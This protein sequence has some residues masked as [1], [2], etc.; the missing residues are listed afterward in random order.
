LEG[1]LGIVVVAEGPAADAPDHRAMPT[2]QGC[3]SRP[4]TT[5]EVVLQQLPIGLLRPVAQ[6]HRPAQ[7]FED[8]ACLA[9]RHVVSLVGAT[10]ALYLTTTRTGPIDALFL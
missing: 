1:V 8:P 5:A 9:V 7:V 2:H 4:F 6:K 3:Q 10:F